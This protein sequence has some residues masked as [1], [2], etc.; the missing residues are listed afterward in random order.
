M[1]VAQATDQRS[2]ANLEAYELQ[3]ETSRRENLI[4]RF[5]L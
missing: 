2:G 3:A 1:Q 4:H 5:I